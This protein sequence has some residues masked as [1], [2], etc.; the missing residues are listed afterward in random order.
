MKKSILF[1]ILLFC[2]S[3]QKNDSND[4]PTYIK[5]NSIDFDGNETAKITDAWVYI[6]DNLQGVYELPAEFPF[7]ESGRK[8]LESELEL[9]KWNCSN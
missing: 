2:F 8:I 7:L 1:F 4:I 5:I 9:R 6:N 3:C